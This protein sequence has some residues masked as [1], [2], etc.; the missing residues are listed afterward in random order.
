MKTRRER[1]VR[2]FY[3][4]AGVPKEIHRIAAWVI[5]TKTTLAITTNAITATFLIAPPFLPPVHSH[6]HFI[7]S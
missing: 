6:V 7:H 2:A 4:S 5:D 3:E 1:E